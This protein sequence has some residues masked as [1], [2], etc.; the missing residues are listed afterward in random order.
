MNKDPIVYL[1]HILECIDIIETYTKSLKLPAF[2]KSIP[3]QD[4]VIRRIQIIDE[5]VKNIPNNVKKE[6]P[7]VEW[8]NIF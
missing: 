7:E 4:T 2:L 5:A 6:Y 3:L 1:D 8:K